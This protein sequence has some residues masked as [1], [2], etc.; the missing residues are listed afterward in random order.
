MGRRLSWA[1]GARKRTQ[2]GMFLSLGLGAKDYILMGSF[3]DCDCVFDHAWTKKGE[4]AFCM[5]S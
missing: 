5:K 2:R 4:I 3:L 1:S